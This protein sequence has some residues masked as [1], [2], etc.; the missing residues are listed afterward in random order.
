M[1]VRLGGLF[2]QCINR[3]E[4]NWTITCN[5]FISTVSG[6][7]AVL[8]KMSQIWVW[9]MNSRRPLWYMPLALAVFGFEFLEYAQCVMLFFG[10]GFWNLLVENTYA[11]S[12]LLY[13]Y[14]QG[15][16]NKL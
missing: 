4:P 15:M 3:L 16:L 14:L 1:V 5:A 8:A 9:C 12:F 2:M 11:F 10:L 7:S 6:W 13:L